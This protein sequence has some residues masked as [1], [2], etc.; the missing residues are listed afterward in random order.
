M[1]SVHPLPPI[2]IKIDTYDGMK[3]Y[4]EEKTTQLYESTCRTCSHHRVAFSILVLL[5]VIL[6]FVIYIV[7]KNNSTTTFPCIA[8]SL[9]TLAND[10]SVTCLTYLWTQNNCKT[11]IDSSPTWMWWLQSPQGL[12]TVKCDN[13]AIGVN[14]GAGSYNTILIY[15]QLCNPSYRG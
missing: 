3:E 14:C 5:G 10:V 4:V 15:T 1:A 12:T 8:Y 13:V 9:D 11:A 6:G 7:V 2:V